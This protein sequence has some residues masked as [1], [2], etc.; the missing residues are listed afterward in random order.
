MPA[1]IRDEIAELVEN[2]PGKREDESQRSSSTWRRKFHVT[3]PESEPPVQRRPGYPLP[4]H[5]HQPHGT[6]SASSGLNP[7]PPPPPP[8]PKRSNPTTGE[9]LGLNNQ[10]VERRSS[11]LRTALMSQ[12]S[13]SS[14]VPTQTS[15]EEVSTVTFFL[16]RAPFGQ[17]GPVA[18]FEFYLYTA[19][20]SRPG[21]GG[22]RTTASCQP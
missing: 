22:S 21:P 15:V 11:A 5:E 6:S 1:N 4:A 19:V 12:M 9:W 13:D 20:D 2:L 10:Q 7:P 8:A 17:Y 3:S 14:P 16:L 18:A